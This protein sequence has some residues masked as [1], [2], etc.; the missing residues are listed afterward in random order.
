MTEL[1]QIITNLMVSDLKRDSAPCSSEHHFAEAM[2]A[3]VALC[4]EW[5]PADDDM[6]ERIN[7]LIELG[8]PMI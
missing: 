1:Q 2:I 5:Q 6:A 8:G 4:P 3:L 7:E